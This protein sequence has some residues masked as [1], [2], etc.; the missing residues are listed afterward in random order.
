MAFTFQLVG[1]MEQMLPGG[2]NFLE[3]IVTKPFSKEL[4]IDME[5]EKRH[6]E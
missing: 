6:L 4:K 3:E 5:V 2:N 1:Q